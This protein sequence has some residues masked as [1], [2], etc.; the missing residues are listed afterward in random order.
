MSW[1]EGMLRRKEGHTS[2][3]GHTAAGAL[4]QYPN[5]QSHIYCH[6][7]FLQLTR[8]AILDK[9]VGRIGAERVSASGDFANHACKEFALRLRARDIVGRDDTV[10]AGPVGTGADR[11]VGDEILLG[12]AL[13][14]ASVAEWAGSDIDDAL[15]VVWLAIFIIG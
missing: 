1:E 8:K 11:E 12:L 14:S 9:D 15:Q 6:F 7:L 5:T 10:H 4:V 3:G 2:G 13:E